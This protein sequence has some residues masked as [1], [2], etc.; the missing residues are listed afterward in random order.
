MPSPALADRAVA[1]YPHDD[2]PLRGFQVPDS[3]RPED[4][5]P[6]GSRP[7]GRRT[8]L[9]SAG[10]SFRG[11]RLHG[12]V[13]LGGRDWALFRPDGAMAPDVRLTLRTHDDAL[14]HMTYGGRWVMP[15]E[16][17]ADLA[18]PTKRYETGRPSHCSRGV[19]GG[20][21]GSGS[22]GLF[23]ARSSST[24]AVYRP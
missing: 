3:T 5:D 7:L 21:G 23:H 18:E 2:T 12:E 24:P 19:A 4:G 20:A 6:C 9:G 10:G 14:V 15:P 22:A 13:L 1:P 17:R 16:L 8:L 11:P